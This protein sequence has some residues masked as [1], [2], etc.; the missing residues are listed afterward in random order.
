MILFSGYYNSVKIIWARGYYNL[1]KMILSRGDYNTVKIIWVRETK[2]GQD[3]LS[4]GMLQLQFSQDSWVSGDYNSV[5]T[6]LVTRDYNSV[7]V[8][9]VRGYYNS[10]NI[11]WAKGYYNPVKNFSRYSTPYILDFKP[12]VCP[13]L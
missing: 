9:L 1:V 10:V 6:I 5:N 7:K 8:I 12:Q 11:I 2:F 3:Y 13:L 4:Q